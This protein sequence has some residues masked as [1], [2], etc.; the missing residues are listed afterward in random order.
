MNDKPLINSELFKAYCLNRTTVNADAAVDAVIGADHGF[1]IGHLDSLTWAVFHAGFAAGAFTFVNFSRHL[2]YL[3]K[4]QPYFS[5]QETKCYK[6][7]ARLQSYFPKNLPERKAS[8][9]SFI[10]LLGILLLNWHQ[11]AELLILRPA[12]QK[13][14]SQVPS[15]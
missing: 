1:A 5:R 4:K 9:T 10:S 14:P 11:R 6:I 12:A 13:R 15:L 7:T 3:S 8:C 2:H